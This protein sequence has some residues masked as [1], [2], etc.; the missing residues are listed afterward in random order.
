[1]RSDCISFDSSTKT[2]TKTTQTTTVKYFGNR[3]RHMLALT[4]Q[5]VKLVILT[6]AEIL[7]VVNE[8]ITVLNIKKE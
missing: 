4:F 3:K 8:K 6:D 7:E 1:M 2:K 5:Y